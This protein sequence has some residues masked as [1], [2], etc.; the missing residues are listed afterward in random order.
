MSDLALLGGEK[1]IVENYADLFKWPIVNEAMEQCLI[2]GTCDRHQ[3][4]RGHPIR[5]EPDHPSSHLSR[6]ALRRL[7]GQCPTFNTPAQRQ[8]LPK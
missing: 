2:A 6:P 7:Q 3:R 1:T 4:R 5:Q 8:S